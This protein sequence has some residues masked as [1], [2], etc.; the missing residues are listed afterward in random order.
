[1]QVSHSLKVWAL[2]AGAGALGLMAASAVVPAQN[3]KTVLMINAIELSGGGATVGT[4][5]RD[6]VDMAVK[7]INGAGGILG[8]KII[9]KHFDTQ[10][11]PGISKAVITKALD[12][13][14]YVVLGPIYSSST[15]VNMVVTRRAGVPHIVGSE[16]ASITQTGNPFIFRTS[17]GQSASMPKLANYLKDEVKAKSVAVVWVNNAFGKGGRDNAVKELKARGIAI[18][19]DISTEVQQADFSAEVVKAKQSGADVLFAYLHEEESA[20]LL[21]ELK[22]Q[23]YDKQIVG[24][25]TLTSQK[26]LDLAKDAANGVKGHVGLTADANIPAIREFARRFE[27]AYGRKP[28]HNGI[29]GYVAVH[30][31]KE[32][33]ERM[34]K[35]DQ[36]GFADALHCTTITT[37]Q[38]PGVL[39]DISYDKNGDVDRASFLVEVRDGKQVVTGVLPKLG[40]AVGC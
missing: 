30:V 31:V 40:N 3:A 22:K 8:R 34:G 6:A 32:I 12:E 11:K 4:N 33:T 14:P 36:K 29:K 39:M 18:A 10:S 5:W 35:F 9:V 37:E 25:T 26:V 15:K 16:A 7:D 24:E 19:A 38:E 28:D 27:A 21:I 1:M 2:S 13:K 23:G 20:R 17:F